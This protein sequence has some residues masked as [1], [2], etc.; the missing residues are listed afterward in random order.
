MSGYAVAILAAAEDDIVERIDY[1]RYRWGDAVA[2]DAY[3]ALM[4]KLELLATQPHMGIVPPELTRLGIATF[5]V[6]VHDTH[7]KV[8]YEIDDDAQSITIHMVY[9]GNQDFQSLLYKRLMRL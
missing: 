4:D 8:L 2:D 7:T 5:R 3:A 6:L 1:V 9:S